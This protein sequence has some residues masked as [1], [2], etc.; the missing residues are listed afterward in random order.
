MKTHHVILL[1]CQRSILELLVS[2]WVGGVE[3][4]ECTASEVCLIACHFSMAGSWDTTPPPLVFFHVTSIMNY[5]NRWAFPTEYWEFPQNEWF[6]KRC[7]IY[8]YYSHQH[9]SVPT[10]NHSATHILILNSIFDI[11]RMRSRT[12]EYTVTATYSY[13]HDYVNR[14]RGVTITRMMQ[15][16]CASTTILHAIGVGVMDWSVKRRLRLECVPGRCIPRFIPQS[17]SSTACDEGI[18][19]QKWPFSTFQNERR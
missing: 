18:L 15:H 11:A 12:A 14:G 7:D 13:K 3:G 9:V 6:E 17:F 4:Q 5:N 1:L 19:H 2:R 8:I 10:I 16:R